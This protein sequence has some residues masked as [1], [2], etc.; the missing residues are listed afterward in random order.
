MKHEYLFHGK[1]VNLKGEPVT[2]WIKPDVKSKRMKPYA[3]P[4]KNQDVLCG[5]ME[6][7]CQ[8]VGMCKLKPK[9]AVQYKWASPAFGV[10][11]KNGTVSLVI[12][13]WSAA[14][15]FNVNFNYQLWRNC[16]EK[17]KYSNLLL[18]SIE[19]GISFAPCMWRNQEVTPICDDSWHVWMSCTCHGSLTICQHVS[20][21]HGILSSDKWNATDSQN[22]TLKISLA[23]KE[24]TMWPKPNG[25]K[26]AVDKK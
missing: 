26:K 17:S 20:I 5:N 7:Q 24:K 21:S 12:D 13:F 8:I 1:C 15:Y 18:A 16:L 2:L 4:L 6:Q 19:N 23:E 14:I 3:I 11:K 10:L 25:K 22:P 9:E